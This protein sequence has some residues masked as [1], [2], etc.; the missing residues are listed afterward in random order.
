MKVV[1]TGAD[2]P[3]GDEALL[4]AALLHDSPLTSAIKWAIL[5]PGSRL[6]KESFVQEDKI[7]DTSSYVYCSF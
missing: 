3:A 2:G 6:S 5:V 7:V 4:K 1:H